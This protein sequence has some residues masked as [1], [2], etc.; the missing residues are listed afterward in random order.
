MAYD[1]FIIHPFY[2]VEDGESFVY[3]Y[4]RLKNGMS[5]CTRNKFVPYFFIKQKDLKKASELK[6]VWFESKE[7][8]IKNFEEEPL[9]KIE[10]KSPKDVSPLRKSFEESGIECF[11]ADIRFEYRFMMD[12]DLKGS[13]T[14]EGNHQKRMTKE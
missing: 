11:E 10:L 8:R 13:I 5:F 1:G 2:K 3:L 12:L 6:T 7:S 14:I 9:A 4:G